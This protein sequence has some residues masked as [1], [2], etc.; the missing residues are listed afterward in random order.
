MVV[1]GLGACSLDYISTIPR[2]PEEDT[3]CEVPVWQL[4]GGGPVP[5]ALVTLSRFKIKTRFMG[6]IGPD[7]AGKNI[8]S[9]LQAENV[10]IRFMVKGYTG[11]SQVAVILVN[12]A[13]GKRTIFWAKS[14]SGEIEEKDLKPSFFEHVCFLH[15]DGRMLNVSI[16]A[17]QEAKKRSIPVMLD[18][19]SMREELIALIEL[20]DYIIA[21][22]R[23]SDVFGQGN[24]ENTVKRLLKKGLKSVTVTLGPKGSITA[25]D[26]KLLFQ[27]AFP[28]KAVDT[29]GAGDVFHGAYIYGILQKWP[30]EKILQFASWASAMKCQ[31]IGGRAG[32]PT[33]E[34]ALDLI[35]RQLKL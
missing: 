13:N 5:T 34:D 2:F 18:A 31:K 10:D 8:Q 9:G 24:H 16:K 32:I 28:V 20:C 25:I 21:S 1:A 23:F 27:P 26:D 30:V 33:F 22:Q 35:N 4:H 6:I 17:A 12:R 19:G 7:E 29:T 11:M 3:K 15:L 14:T